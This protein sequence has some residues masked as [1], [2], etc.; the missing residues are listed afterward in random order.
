MVMNKRKVTIFYR[1]MKTRVLLLGIIA[2]VVVSCTQRAPKEMGATTDVDLDKQ[3]DVTDKS[4][5]NTI[6]SD[7]L[8]GLF[9]E[10]T[11]EKYKEVKKQKSLNDSVTLFGY[12]FLC[13][14][15]F[16]N[17]SLTRLLFKRDYIL[18]SPKKQP[19]EKVLTK[20]TAKDSLMFY[21][22]LD[23]LEIR[24]GVADKYLGY[25]NGV[26]PVPRSMC[27]YA[28][29]EYQNMTIEMEDIG[30]DY[31]Q[32]DTSFNYEGHSFLIRLSLPVELTER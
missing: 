17:K 16:A 23:S 13:Q 32:S 2:C 9:L 4:H 22:I 12:S 30:A 19:N 26:D 3:T 25:R 24:Y 28:R 11:V 7:T 20:S 10:M 21:S 6:G 31:V 1:T 5:A 8:S 27:S 14:P 29:W 18:C 15:T